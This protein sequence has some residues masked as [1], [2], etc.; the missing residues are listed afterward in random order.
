MRPE[1][2]LSLLLVLFLPSASARERGAAVPVE[3]H[4]ETKGIL[5]AEEELALLQRRIDREDLPKVQFE[6]DS[7]KVRPESA[8][9]LDLL[10]DLLRRNPQLKLF[11]AAHTCAIG[12]EEYNLR[13]SQ[14]RAKAVKGE[15]VKRGIPPPS[16]RFRGKGFSEPVADNDTPEGREKNRRVEFKILKRWWSAVY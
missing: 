13:L 15:L 7:W 14:R 5:T 11:I 4:E 16:I 3:V 10:A 8:P 6:F 12:S 1:A 2:G 9:T